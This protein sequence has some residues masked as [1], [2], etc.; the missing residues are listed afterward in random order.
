[1]LSVSRQTGESLGVP[2]A[3]RIGVHTGPVVAGIIGTHKFS[4]DVWG[5][6]VNTAS[7]MESHGAANEINVSEAAYL[8]LRDKFEFQPRGRIELAGKGPVEAY[9]LRGR[10]GAPSAE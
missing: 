10:R 1:M 2:L 8:R 9:F 4:Y 5:D 6:T 7:R 3:M